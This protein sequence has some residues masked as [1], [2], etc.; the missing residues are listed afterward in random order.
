M[1]DIRSLPFETCHTSE[2]PVYRCTLSYPL[3]GENDIFVPLYT[4]ATGLQV[5]KCHRG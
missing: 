2:I 1:A 4:D 3:E 5:M